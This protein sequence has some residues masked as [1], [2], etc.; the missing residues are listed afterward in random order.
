MNI[1]AVFPHKDLYLLKS[2]VF[3]AAILGLK[4][5]AMSATS[6]ATRPA[7]ISE[8]F[9]HAKAL[10]E[11]RC[12]TA[13][14]V[15]KKTV[16]DVEG[17]ELLTIRPKL[18]WGDKRYFDPMFEGAAMG[19]EAQGDSYIASFLY[20]E[21]QV[22]NVGGLRGLIQPP[23]MKSGST[24]SASLPGY[25]Y[26]DATDP[27]DGKVWRY[28]VSKG[29]S[30]E[31]LLKRGGWGKDIERNIRSSEAP[32]YAVDFVDMAD[33]DDRKYWIAGTKIRVLDRQSGE[34]I[35]ELTRYVWDSGFGISTTGRWPWQHASAQGTNVCPSSPVHM[36]ETRY[37]VDKVLIPRRE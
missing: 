35:A 21:L 1:A 7:V 18:E 23:S 29:I 28:R 11:A 3:V 27:I 34:V 25:Q 8:Q 31:E 12:K 5:C 22:T 32:R 33:A 36:Y 24:G 17:I 9:G 6:I 10:F 16:S 2:A 13:G 4:G 19:A 14:A 26:V 37:F 15:I 30:T 20:S